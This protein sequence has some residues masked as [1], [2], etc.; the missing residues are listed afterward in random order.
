M[1]FYN[2]VYFFVFFLFPI[3]VVFISVHNLKTSP[4]SQTSHVLI[5]VFIFS[6]SVVFE[7]EKVTDN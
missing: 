4:C 5:H 2:F 6:D 1:E 3:S 7:M